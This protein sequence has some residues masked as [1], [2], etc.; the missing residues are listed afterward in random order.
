M[1]PEP[2]NKILPFK[3][4]DPMPKRWVCPPPCS[5]TTFTLWTDGKVHCAH[6]MSHHYKIAFTVDE[7]PLDAAS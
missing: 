3:H 7:T 6:C 1:T 4:R 5:S 2:Q